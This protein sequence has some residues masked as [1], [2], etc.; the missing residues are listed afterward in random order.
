MKNTR[1]NPASTQHRGRNRLDLC[2]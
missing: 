2:A 1:D